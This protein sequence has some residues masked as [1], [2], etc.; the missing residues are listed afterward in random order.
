[1]ARGPKRRTDSS[2]AVEA[3][4]IGDEKSGGKADAKKEMPPT[5]KLWFEEAWHGW[6]KPLGLIVVLIGAYF[7][8]DRGVL[9]EGNAGLVVVA[10]IV[11]VTIYSVAEQAFPLLA[12][13]QQRLALGGFIAVWALA[14]G[15][16]SLRAAFPTKVLNTAP[17]TVAGCNHWKDADR[18]ECADPKL[19]ANVALPEGSGPYEVE[20]SG[21]L[22]G[23]GEAESS[24]H[25]TFSGADSAQE[26][27][28]G[29][30]KRTYVRQRT[31]RRGSGGVSV[32]QERTEN[33]HRILVHG[34]SVKVEADGV[35][36]TLE[37]GLLLSFHSA[38]PDPRIFLILG[39]L[40][41]LLGIAL[42]YWFAAPKVKTYFGL[43]TGL[44][45]A[46]AAYFPTE[47]TP[48]FLVRPAVAALIFALVT[49]GLGGWLLAIVAKSFKPKP[50][51]L[52]K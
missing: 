41:V 35:D 16:P 47:A 50:K 48:H 18:K 19:V 2:P 42:D 39:A 37:N 28:D 14:A 9:P 33:S 46:F 6:M 31:S 8:Y 1:M 38:G 3:G 10:L 22:R 44:T 24:Y 27:V 34:P 49:G 40:C 4:E 26:T 52:V 11:G 21:E 7:L 17:V 20:V 36:D 25:L 51:K 45:L 30:L 13:R 43:G 12:R 15:Y 23:T 29:T 5:F 32:R